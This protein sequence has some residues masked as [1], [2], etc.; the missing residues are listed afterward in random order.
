MSWR[1]SFDGERVGREQRR[2][3]LRGAGEGEQ[4]GGD[5]GAEGS[6][7]ADHGG[8]RTRR[9]HSRRR[10][11]AFRRGAGARRGLSE[12]FTGEGCN[13]RARNDYGGTD[14]SLFSQVARFARSP[15]G[16]A[17][18]GRGDGL[19]PEPEGP[20][21]DR[22]GAP[23][24]R[25][26]Q[27]QAQAALSGS[28]RAWFDPPMPSGAQLIVDLLEEQG[29]EVA[30]GL[31]GVHNLAALGGAARRRRSGSSASA[32][33]RRPPTPPTAT[34]AP[35]ASSASPSPRPARGR[36]TRS[37]PSARRG[38]RARR[39]S[40]I[41]TDIPAALRR[42]GVY[43]GVLHETTDQAA[44]FAP[45]VKAAHTVATA[46]ELAL[47]VPAAR[48]PTPSPRRRAPSTWACRPTCSRAER[49]AAPPGSR[50][51]TAQPGSA[52]TPS[53]SSTRPSGR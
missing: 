26:A 36:P 34:P 21:E 37:A 27:R 1:P 52:T 38:P 17:R 30:F 33:S 6:R 46:Q 11:T 40:S 24:A 2:C 35:P 13:G 32:T 3:G 19:R 14:M 48:S 15:H 31:P 20:R 25:A 4:R 44:M 8:P 47:T 12:P 29:V 28:R 9:G 41:A 43:R 51:G 5:E 10:R 53:R 7:G 39:C 16:R 23:A 49:A 45:V 22:P 50:P 42:P 18:R